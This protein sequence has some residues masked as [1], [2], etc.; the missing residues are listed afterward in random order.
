MSTDGQEPIHDPIDLLDELDSIIRAQN[1]L[2]HRTIALQARY[3]T[4]QPHADR[5]DQQDPASDYRRLQIGAVN[6]ESAALRL[7]YAAESDNGMAWLAIA[8]ES[9]AKI[10]EYPQSE[11]STERLDVDRRRSR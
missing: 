6:V 7:G 3:A 10:R 2:R 9:A 5:F 4:L 11:L 8:R 1:M